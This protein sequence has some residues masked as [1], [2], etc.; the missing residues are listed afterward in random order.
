MLRTALH[1]I[2]FP[3]A[4]FTVR[5]IDTDEAAR[6]CRFAGSP[7]FVVNGIDVFDT[8]DGHGSMACRVYVTPDGPSNLPALRDLCD[9]LKRRAEAA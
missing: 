6:A 5:L 7:A 8:G 2:G 1:D 9:A 3:D 4:T